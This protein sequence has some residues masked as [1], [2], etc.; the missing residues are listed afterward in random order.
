MCHS[1][2]SSGIQCHPGD[3]VEAGC[4]AVSVKSDLKALPSELRNHGDF[5]KCKEEPKQLFLQL[6]S[7]KQLSLLMNSSVR[8][9]PPV[10]NG[11]QTL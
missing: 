6:I 4:L 7:F 5:L 9:M 1:L 2:Q 8:Q 11:Q 3:I 10:Q